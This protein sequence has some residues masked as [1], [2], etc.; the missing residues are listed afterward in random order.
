MKE[1]SNPTRTSSPKPVESA[2]QWFG[3][4]GLSGFL[5]LNEAAGSHEHTLPSPCQLALRCPHAAPGRW[6]LSSRLWGLQRPARAWIQEALP[7]PEHS[8]R[9]HQSRADPEQPRV[10]LGRWVWNWRRGE[11]RTF[12]TTGDEEGREKMRWATHGNERG[13]GPEDPKKST[14]KPVSLTRGHASPSMISPQCKWSEH[15]GQKAYHFTALKKSYA[16]KK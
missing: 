16:I 14:G 2:S 3:L 9:C 11:G 7:D 12:Q 5:Q 13:W 1:K 15:E 6:P 10:E 4:L 8:P